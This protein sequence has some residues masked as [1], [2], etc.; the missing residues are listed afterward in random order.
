MCEWNRGTGATRNLMITVRFSLC[1]RAPSSYVELEFPSC[2]LE[3]VRVVFRDGHALH[4]M[5]PS[6]LGVLSQKDVGESTTAD[7]L[8][9]LHL[10]ATNGDRFADAGTHNAG[11]RG[12]R[13]DE[14]WMSTKERTAEVNAQW[15]PVKAEREIVA[16]QSSLFCFFSLSLLQAGVACAAA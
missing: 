5:L 12:Y 8:H 4:R 3:V 14:C 15:S 10:H 1:I 9:D 7:L 13:A 16:R 6:S 11:E 2:D